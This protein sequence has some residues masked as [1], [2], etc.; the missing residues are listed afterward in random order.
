MMRE[1]T[2][3]ARRVDKKGKTKKTQHYTAVKKHSKKQL[4]LVI[5]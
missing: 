4:R 1:W 5:P 3:R 2:K